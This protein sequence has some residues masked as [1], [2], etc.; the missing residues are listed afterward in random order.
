VVLLDIFFRVLKNKKNFF[1]EK[2]VPQILDDF[3]YYPY[4]PMIIDDFCR[5]SKTPQTAK[6]APHFPHKFFKKH[7][8]QPK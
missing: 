8:K 4:I 2:K 7:H 5:F 6:I 1:P 3:D